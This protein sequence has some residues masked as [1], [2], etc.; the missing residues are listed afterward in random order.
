MLRKGGSR[1]RKIEGKGQ[2]AKHV[3][4]VGRMKR[5]RGAE[6]ENS[7]TEEESQRD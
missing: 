7:R 5:S 6:E 4:Y 1:M 2:K 3:L